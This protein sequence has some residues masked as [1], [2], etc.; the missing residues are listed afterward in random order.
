MTNATIHA[1]VKQEAVGW[2]ESGRSMGAAARIWDMVHQTLFNWG[3]ASRQGT[4]KGADGASNLSAEQMEISRAAGR[5]GACESGK[6]RLFNDYSA[7]RLPKYAQVVQG[8][9]VCGLDCWSRFPS[10]STP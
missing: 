7:R 5:V 3:K 6:V 9:S 2:V 8:I 1:G 4:L 10:L